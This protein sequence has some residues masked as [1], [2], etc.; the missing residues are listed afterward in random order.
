[1]TPLQRKF[2]IWETDRSE[3]QDYNK[4]VRD[5]EIKA[6]RAN[7]LIG[8]PIARKSRSLDEQAAKLSHE[9]GFQYTRKQILQY[10]CTR[11]SE[12]DHDVIDGN[13]PGRSVAKCQDIAVCFRDEIRGAV[14]QTVK[15]VIPA[16]FLA[17]TCDDCYEC[18]INCRCK[19]NRR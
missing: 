6:I 5:L 9:E 1:M 16:K 14:E 13:T 12:H 15:Q 3:Q 7:L 19:L 8:N 18:I 11:M 17:V 2:M 4:W 10:E